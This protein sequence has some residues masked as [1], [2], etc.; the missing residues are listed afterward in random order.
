M[1][2]NIYPELVGFR[3]N[4]AK[5]P[6]PEFPHH[7]PVCDAEITIRHRWNCR[8]ECGGGY[9]SKPQIQNHTEKFWGKCGDPPPDDEEES[10]KDEET[11]TINR[12]VPGTLTDIEKEEIE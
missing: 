7:C 12:P 4:G 9:Q 2:E 10:A 1:T 3:V 8:Y 11:K 5:A 6:P